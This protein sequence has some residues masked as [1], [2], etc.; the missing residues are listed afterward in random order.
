MRPFVYSVGVLSYE[1]CVERNLEGIKGSESIHENHCVYESFS[2]MDADRIHSFRHP[3]RI[4]ETH[5][6]CGVCKAVMINPFSL[7]QCGHIFCRNCTFNLALPGSDPPVV[8][9]PVCRTYG[10]ATPLAKGF[11]LLYE[12]I[13]MCC[14]HFDSGC[15]KAVPLD[16]LYLHENRYCKY[17]KQTCPNLRCRFV[18]SREEW[19]NQHDPDYCPYPTWPVNPIIAQ[20]RL[21]RLAN[22]ANLRR[23]VSSD[24]EEV[25][26]E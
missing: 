26:S 16:Q 12:S 3:D 5:F 11:A 1:L 25:E 14:K 21:Y 9:C 15:R 17:L 13:E 10:I 18:G 23:C 6:T 2:E 19:T 20:S 24:V 4:P 22:R 7:N 8:K